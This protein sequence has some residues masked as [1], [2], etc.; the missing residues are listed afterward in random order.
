MDFFE[1]IE[2]RY[3]Y[4]G[5]FTGQE[6]PAADVER[7]LDAGIRAPSGRAT[8]STRFVVVTDKGLRGELAA[9]FPHKG[10]A[11]APVLIAV[12][13]RPVPVYGD[14][15]FELQ[16]YAAAVENM[17]LA[18]T[19]LGYATVWTDGDMADGVRGPAM[20]MALNAPEGWTVRCVLPIGIPE[21]PGHQ[22]E[23]DAFPALVQYNRF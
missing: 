8:A 14:K 11:S 7:I 10:I 9:I 20:A 19:A 22:K 15:V 23:K 3:S 17:L 5:A 16:N 13:T 6:V 4:R 18:A 2:K 12:L 21:Q 1:A